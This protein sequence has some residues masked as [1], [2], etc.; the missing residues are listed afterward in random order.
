MEQGVAQGQALPGAGRFG[1]WGCFRSRLLGMGF[2]GAVLWRSISSA[3]SR[4]GLDFL[5]AKQ[6]H[7]GVHRR[8]AQPHLGWRMVVSGTR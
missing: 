1:G 7:H 4:R 6:G 2:G 8:V 3:A 5:A